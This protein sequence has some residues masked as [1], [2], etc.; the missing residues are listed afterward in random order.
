MVS[1]TCPNCHIILVEAT[2]NNNSDLYAAENE[3][4]TL[5]A[6]YVSN[7]WGGA[8]Y[9]GETA[10]DQYFNHPGVVITAA[11]GDSGYLGRGTAN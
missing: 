6:K 11:G 9:S 5:G 3:A 1:A 7:S 2:S 8:E 10:D 4:V